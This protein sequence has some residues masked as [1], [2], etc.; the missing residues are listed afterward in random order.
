VWAATATGTVTT[1]VTGIIGQ[2][3]GVDVLELMWGAE[4]VE[5]WMLV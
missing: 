2:W 5:D 3:N 1:V 4:P